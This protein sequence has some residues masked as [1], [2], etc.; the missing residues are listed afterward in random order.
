MRK[1]FFRKQTRC[2][3]VWINDKMVRL[4]KNE[5]KAYEKWHR[6]VVAEGRINADTPVVTV[7][8]EFLEVKKS[9]PGLADRT[10]DWYRNFIQSFASYLHA[11]NKRMKLGDVTDDHLVRWIG[12][13]YR[14]RSSST[15][16]GAM[17]AVQAAFRWAIR[18]GYTSHSKVLNAKKPSPNRRETVISPEQWRKITEAA[19]DQE[20]RDL[21]TIL[22]ETGCR[23]Q[24]ARLAE[25]AFLDEA[26]RRLV[27]PLSKSK[28]GQVARVVYLSPTALTVV[29]RLAR[30]HPE[31]PLLRNSHGT[32]WT[33]H[34]IRCRFK[35][36]R[37]KLK[38][39][40][41]CAYTIR[42]TWIT[43]ALKRGLDSTTVGILAGHQDQTMVA[44]N[45]QHLTQD[46]KYLAEQ[47]R[48][49]RAE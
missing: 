25:A 16:H 9:E 2:W 28:G 27:F 46:A 42:H 12:K 41:L 30:Q 37:E 18:K 3:Y 5:E 32:P 20:F 22:W 33:R 21:L 31:D 36:L 6:L 35:R 4:A 38:I 49:A 34:S 19:T 47:A 11:R 23:P 1:P 29:R 26:N 24:E 39:T 8:D 15:V 7:L 45:Y 14:G 48:K 13:C 40:E 44:R 17:R 43:D 10:Y